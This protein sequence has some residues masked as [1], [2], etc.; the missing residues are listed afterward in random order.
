MRSRIGTSQFFDQASFA[1]LYLPLSLFPSVISHLYASSCI[2]HLDALYVKGFLFVSS[3]NCIT[4]KSSNIWHGI[5]NLRT[6]H[7][8]RSPGFGHGRSVRDYNR[9]K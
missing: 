9:L 2:L 4:A 3:H 6:S 8:L 5:E 7:L 1:E